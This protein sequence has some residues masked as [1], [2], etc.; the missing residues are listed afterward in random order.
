M[1]W[2]DDISTQQ[3]LTVDTSQCR[4]SQT[5]VLYRL[6]ISESRWWPRPLI[7]VTWLAMT[8]R[9][10]RWRLPAAAAALQQSA[11]VPIAAIEAGTVATYGSVRIAGRTKRPE[12]STRRT[13]SE[14]RRSKLRRTPENH[15]NNIRPAS[16]TRW[17]RQRYVQTDGETDGWRQADRCCCN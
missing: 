3:R 12:W 5:R 15:S 8:S 14:R 4:T 7:S 6:L 13:C 9:V 1:S 16:Q 2:N 10:G 11:R 17:Y